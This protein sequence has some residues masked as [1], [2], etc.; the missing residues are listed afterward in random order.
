MI[1]NEWAGWL[2]LELPAVE[3]GIIILKIVTYMGEE[4]N[5]RTK[6]WTTVNNERRLEEEQ[7]QQQVEEQ[8]VDESHPQLPPANERRRTKEIDET[9]PEDFI[10]DYAIDGKITS[11]SKAEFLELRKKPQRVMEMLTLLDDPNFTSSARDV[12]VAFRMRNCGRT[13]TFALS[14][15][16]WA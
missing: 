7:Q 3:E 1:G 8:I 16:Y 10:F 2:V 5:K 14:H 9:L 6:G 12:E 15:V 11:L 4:V 13:C